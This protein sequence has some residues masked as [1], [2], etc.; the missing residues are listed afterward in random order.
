VGTKRVYD[1][2]VETD[3]CYLVN[4]IWSH[5][6]NSPNLTNLPSHGPMGKATK[7]C[8]V[9]PDGWLFA[10]A[11]YS[12]L[13]ERIGAILSKDPNRIKVYTDGYDG[14]SMRAQKYFEEQMPDIAAQLKAAETATKFWIDDKGEYQCE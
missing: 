10:G 4:G 11:D 6:S 2:E 3:H 8:I 1:V 9:A 5:N 12:A 13:E 14:H 7:S